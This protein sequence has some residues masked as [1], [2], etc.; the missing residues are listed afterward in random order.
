MVG[1][2]EITRADI[3]RHLEV[4]SLDAPLHYD[5]DVAREQGYR[6]IVAPAGML[7]GSTLPAYWNP[8]DPPAGDQ[9]MMVPMPMEQIPTPATHW[10]ATEVDTEFLEPVY[11]GDRIS[12]TMKLVS[13]TPKRTRVGEGAFMV[14][15]STYR[16]QTGEVVA[17]ERLTTF[18]HT[19]ASAEGGN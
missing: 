12:R 11:P 13:V 18:R 3:R 1:A 5:E 16:K 17:V 8:G 2:D 10:L 9:R 14:V 4:L 19:P 15:E 6:T 7:S